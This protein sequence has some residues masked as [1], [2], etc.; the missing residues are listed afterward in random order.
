MNG[1][2]RKGSIFVIA[3][4]RGSFLEIQKGI[5]RTAQR[6]DMSAHREL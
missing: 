4:F 1:G 5:G 3:L 2:L 6:M